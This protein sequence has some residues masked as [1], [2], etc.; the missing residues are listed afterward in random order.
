MYNTEGFTKKAE[1]VIDRAFMQAG[2]LG[3]TYM[4]SEHLLL[5][6]CGDTDT[7]AGR[8]LKQWGIKEKNVLEIIIST[9][10]RG[11]P[12]IVEASSV[13]PAVRKIIA[14]AVKEASAAGEQAGTEHILRSVLRCDG[15]T[16]V[17]VINSAGGDVSGLNGA[18]AADDFKSG[19]RLNVLYKYARDLTAEAAGKK[20]D[21]VIARDNEIRRVMQILS[22][23][24]K[25]NPCLVGEAG[26]GKTAVVEGIAAR[27]AQGDVPDVLRRKHIFSISLTSMIAGAKYRGDFEER[28]KQCIDEVV[29]NG[30]IILFIDEIHSI[31]G[32]GAAEGAI[33][34][35]NILKPQLAR[36]ELQVIGATTLNE[37]RRY[38][39]KDSAL[40]RRFQQVLINEPVQEDAVKIIS[41]IKKCYEDFHNARIT[42]EA[43]KAAVELSVRYQPERFLPDKAVDLIDEAASRARLKASA[44]PQT[45][46]QLADSLKFMLEK[47]SRP[48][49]K[50]E[51][52]SRGE[53]PSW[54]SSS[55]EKA[56]VVD[57]E[58]V[59]EVI[60]DMTGIPLKK[61]TKD[62]GERLLCLEEELHRRVIGQDKAVRAVA[63]AVRRS[64]SG[65]K[66][67]SRPMGCFLFSGPTGSGKTE[68]SKALAECLFGDENALI[69][70]D[71]SEYMEK[72]SVS[73]LIGSPPGYVG[74][75]EGGFLTE[76][77]RRKPY[78][79]ILFDEIEKAHGDISNL[80]LQI[81]E[82]GVLT[83]S[84]GR[85][86]SFRNTVV[87]LTSNIGAEKLSDS[88]SIGFVENGSTKSDVMKDIKGFFKPELLGRLDEI[89]VFDPLTSSELT[90]ITVK[91]LD[92]LRKRAY[93]LEISVE[94]SDEAVKKLSS[95]GDNGSGARDLRRD[96]AFSVENM[97][98]RRIIDGSVKRG[99]SL[100][101][102]LENGELCFKSAQ[103]QE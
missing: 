10:G 91:I 71:M 41:G 43:V 57:R 34:A 50:R 47:Q 88:K 79:V 33:D 72:H 59:A 67:S 42:D 15:C 68:L 7:G 103:M 99:D 48:C 5:A 12:C 26:V 4:G 1:T 83:D 3:H 52:V 61:L 100:I 51:R 22:R 95:G 44:S 20:F 11:E 55:E 9:V 81:F 13:T 27:L 28:V 58:Q 76:K 66:E 8:L 70:L 94:F 92:G 77:V 16:A 6:L 36:G 78:S 98:S 69:R 21:P 102:M 96:I 23:R 45:L 56:V 37:Y 29:E 60:S 73:K 53:L 18:Y 31:V 75:D 84:S 14:D 87:I 30:N 90:D 89:I 35:A 32:A 19:S 82:E 49:E 24:T 85:T 74:Y 17:S 64:R 80:L 40:E 39:E 38:I 63:D 62:E 93:A 54:Y 46:A 97:L 25:N 101:L 2:R 65:L 86:V